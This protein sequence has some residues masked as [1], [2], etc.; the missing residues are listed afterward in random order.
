[1]SMI[2]GP[3]FLGGADR[4]GKT[5]MRLM[6]SSHPEVV[7]T[8][9]TNMWT[10]YFGRFGEL[11]SADNLNRCLTALFRNKHI[12]ALAIDSEQLRSMFITGTQTYARLFALI[13]EQYARR[14]GRLRW[15]D[16]TEG[17]E[18]F[19][20]PIF[21][22]YPHARMIH[23]LR[24]VRDH[25]AASKSGKLNKTKWVGDSVARWLASVSVAEKNLNR[26][27]DAYKI[28][29]YESMVLNTQETIQ[30]VCEFLELPYHDFMLTMPDSARFKGRIDSESSPISS[31]F[32]GIYRRLISL[33]ELAFIQQYAGEALKRYGYSMDPIHKVHRNNRDFIQLGWGINL[34]RMRTWK[35]RILIKREIK[36]RLGV[37]G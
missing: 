26:Y 31:D 12:R 10:D 8:R 15:G 30:D 20:S 13:H 29:K 19:T 2:S 35:S 22:A 17:V 37:W 28:V 6:L 23:M 14:V 11:S 27:P 5:Y 7:F 24:D 33:D 3:I 32:I 25:Y 9:R 16:Q 36:Y 18:S 34:A 21:E 4:S 1:M